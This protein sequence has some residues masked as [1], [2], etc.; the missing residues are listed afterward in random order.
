MLLRLLF[1]LLSLFTI[2][3]LAFCQLDHTGR[4]VSGPFIA[5]NYKVF[6]NDKGKLVTTFDIYRRNDGS[7]LERVFLGSPYMSFPIWQSG[8]VNIDGKGED[9]PCQIAYNL[10]TDEIL[11]R[12][13][14][15]DKET[16]VIPIAFSINGVPF[17][18]LPIKF[19]GT[20]TRTYFAVFN[21]GTTKFL[22]NYRRQHETNWKSK[23]A[24]DFDGEYV[25]V[26]RYYIRKGSADP[27]E[28]KLTTESLLAALP[29]KANQLKDRL[30]SKK[31]LT[32]DEVI[33]ALAY[34]DTLVIE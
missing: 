29:E 28:I 7:V 34:Y 16:P 30:R 3:T 13:P 6:E 18:S 26:E 17:V 20:T 33:A 27:V 1:I 8:T 15:S 31:K 12:F 19:L 11:C 5:K 9:V 25:T 24:R 2:N 21:T 14:D 32:K 4:S 22:V 23:D 10:F